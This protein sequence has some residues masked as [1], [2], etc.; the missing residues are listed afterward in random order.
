MSKSNTQNQV[1]LTYD[2][3]VKFLDEIVKNSFSMW[4]QNLDVQYIKK[5]EQPLM[6]RCKDKT[7]KL[8]INFDKWVTQKQYRVGHTRH[9]LFS[10]QNVITNRTVCSYRS[11]NFVH[12]T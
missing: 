2:E 7:T 1:F 6:V 3:I 11:S 10:F 5:L 8:N 4:S 12:G 9:K